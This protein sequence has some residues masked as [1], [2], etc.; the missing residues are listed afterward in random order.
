MV[1][2]L[3]VRPRSPSKVAVWSKAA[4]GDG[5]C[6]EPIGALR[7]RP[8]WGPSPWTLELAHI[9]IVVVTTRTT[10]RSTLADGSVV[11]DAAGTASLEADP[12]I[13]AYK[14]GV[15]RTLL[16]EN[17]RLTTSDRVTKMIAALRFAEAVRRSR[18]VSG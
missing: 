1:G 7:E 18:P 12:T 15:D 16:R 6:R 5:G 10:V 11:A 3:Q 13:D 4:H 8:L 14:A 17:L 9:L 2:W